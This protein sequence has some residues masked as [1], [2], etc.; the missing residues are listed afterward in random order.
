M[1]VVIHCVQEVHYRIDDL[2]HFILKAVDPFL[3]LLPHQLIGLLLFA[4]G[5]N[6]LFERALT[7]LQ[8]CL[9]VDSIVRTALVHNFDVLVFMLHYF[10]FDR[11]VVA[12]FRVVSYFA[13]D[14]R[15][16]GEDRPE[17]ELLG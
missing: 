16:L 10:V 4:H 3:K 15:V 1:K 7:T 12:V 14:L 11:A 2:I 8:L 9:E 13:I 6:G 17:Q 5:V